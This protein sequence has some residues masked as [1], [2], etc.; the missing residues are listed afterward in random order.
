MRSDLKV[1][2]ERVRTAVTDPPG[3]PFVWPEASEALTRAVMDGLIEIP[4]HDDTDLD[5]I[6]PKQELL[7]SLIIN[8]SVEFLTSVCANK[9]PE[10]V[11]V[12]VAVFMDNLVSNIVENVPVSIEPVQVAALG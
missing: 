10:E 3:A 7:E 2:I 1:L 5:G 6:S 9:K 11:T 8:L 4:L 12:M